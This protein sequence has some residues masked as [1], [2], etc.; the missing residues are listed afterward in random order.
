MWQASDM[1]TESTLV[2]CVFP[3]HYCVY[4]IFDNMG[5]SNR[6]KLMSHRFV[7]LVV[8]L[9]CK[10]AVSYHDYSLPIGNQSHIPQYVNDRIH[11]L[12]H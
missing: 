10:S 8:I 2:V 4:H 12:F 6:L 11:S 9:P 1:I 7:I 5:C 3:V